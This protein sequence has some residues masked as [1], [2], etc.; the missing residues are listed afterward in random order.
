M[1][2]EDAVKLIFEMKIKKLSVVEKGKLVGLVSITD[3]ARFHPHIM[4][5]IKKLA[6]QESMPKR[7]QKVMCYYI[8]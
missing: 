8:S 2:L 4:E 6:A 3:V 7:I 1:D 5:I